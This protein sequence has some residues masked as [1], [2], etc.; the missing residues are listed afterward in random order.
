[1][2]DEEWATRE[3]AIEGLLFLLT[4]ATQKMSQDPKARRIFAEEYPL[5]VDPE[6][7]KQLQITAFVNM[8][9]KIG[10]TEEEIKSATVGIAL[11]SFIEDHH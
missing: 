4:F 1:M 8:L 2:M 6:S 7:F 11:S 3:S 9:M 5:A 10:V